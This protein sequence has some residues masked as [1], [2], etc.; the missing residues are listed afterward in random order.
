MPL[1]KISQVLPANCRSMDEIKES[2]T[3]VSAAVEES[4][5]GIVN[6]A[7][8]STDLTGSCGRISRK[9]AES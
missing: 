3:A 2:T 6:V 1:W 9:A 7:E 4:A 5:K 8:M